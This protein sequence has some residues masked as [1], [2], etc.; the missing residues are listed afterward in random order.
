MELTLL[1]L[2]KAPPIFKLKI[3]GAMELTLLALIKA[4]PIFNLKE[5]MCITMKLLVANMYQELCLWTWSPGP[6]TLYGQDPSGKFS[7]RTTLC[8]DRVGPETTG[9]RGTTQ[10]GRSW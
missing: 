3:G 5:S 1:A 8:S 10:R 2:T 7:G 4:P 9:L 6:W